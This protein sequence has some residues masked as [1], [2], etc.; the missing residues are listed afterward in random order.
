MRDTRSQR[1]CGQTGRSPRD[2]KPAK[3]ACNEA[4]PLSRASSI[5]HLSAPEG[6]D[7]DEFNPEDRAHFFPVLYATEA[8]FFFA[9]SSF[10]RL[11]L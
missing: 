5:T 10:T 4:Y 8:A 3:A 1:R 11:I 6:S 7:G 2:E 9:S